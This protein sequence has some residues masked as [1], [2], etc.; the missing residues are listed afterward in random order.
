MGVKFDYTEEKKKTNK[1]DVEYKEE[2]TWTQS[3]SI[4]LLSGL[5]S[6]KG[7]NETSKPPFVL[8]RMC[9]HVWAFTPLSCPSNTV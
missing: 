7:R 3:K 1:R 4:S 9:T 8:L 6:V 5:T 2:M